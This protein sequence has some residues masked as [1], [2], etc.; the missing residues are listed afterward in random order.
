[1]GAAIAKTSISDGV[2]DKGHPIN[3]ICVQ[4][5]AMFEAREGYRTIKGIRKPEIM[6]PK[7]RKM[8]Q[9]EFWEKYK[10]QHKLD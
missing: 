10:T 5:F 7:C 8:E 6:C 3:V 1:M 2:I 9:K 4:C